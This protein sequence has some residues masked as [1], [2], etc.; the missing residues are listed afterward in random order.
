MQSE[1]AAGRAR[2][3]GVS[4]MSLRHLQ[5]MINRGLR[6]AFVQNRCYARLGWDF[7]IRQFCR[8]HGIVY[9]GFS[10]LTANMEVLDSEL[11]TQVAKRIQA[12]PAQVI[13]AF[14]RQVGMLPLTGTSNEQHMKADLASKEIDLTAKDVQA[15]EMVAV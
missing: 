12:T 5:Q 14:A 1:Q 3:L 10:L 15:I 13:F 7:H 9:Q 2:V 8:E 6:P 11:L 4:N